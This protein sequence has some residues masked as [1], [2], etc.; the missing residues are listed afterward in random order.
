MDR[1]I[2]I[3]TNVNKVV[4][5]FAWGPVMLVLLV[6]TGIYLTVL[7]R[8]I[9][10]RRFGYIL[11]NTIGTIRI[12]YV[13]TAETTIHRIIYLFVIII[14]LFFKRPQSCCKATYKYGYNYSRPS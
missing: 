13:T 4:N 14:L 5:G 8:G 1:F 3:V 7:T 2:E 11:K 6:G 9:Q 10:V 12:R